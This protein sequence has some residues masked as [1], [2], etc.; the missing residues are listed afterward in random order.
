[1]S[2]LVTPADAVAAVRRKLDQKWAEAVRA[3]LDVR[4]RRL[5]LGQK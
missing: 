4:I 1:M 5:L 2:A 3:D